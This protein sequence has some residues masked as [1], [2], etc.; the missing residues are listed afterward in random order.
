[1]KMMKK[2][3]SIFLLV[4]IIQFSFA[5]EEKITQVFFI[6]HAEKVKDGSDDPALTKMGQQRATYW[7]E[8]FKNIDFDAV[9]STQTLRT[10]STALPCAVQSEVEISIYDAKEVD[11][12]KLVAKHNGKSIL[13]VGHSNSTPRLVNTLIGEEKFEEIIHHNNSNLYIAS[14]DGENKNVSLLYIESSK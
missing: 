4:F 11:I 8:V 9:Y 7:A 5:Q 1:M 12:N 13:I 10:T 14:V 2:A 3:I 6:R